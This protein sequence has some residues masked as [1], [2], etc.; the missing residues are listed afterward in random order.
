[1]CVGGVGV[2]VCVCMC[3]C[4]YVWV[5]VCEGGVGWVYNQ[6]LSALLMCPSLGWRWLRQHTGR[7]VVCEFSWRVVVAQVELSQPATTSGR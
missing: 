7:V 5:C 4:V 1:M 3:V 2:C 6:L